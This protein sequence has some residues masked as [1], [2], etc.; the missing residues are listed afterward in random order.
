MFSSSQEELEPYWSLPELEPDTDHLLSR[1][2]LVVI[3]S[4]TQSALHV[5][6]RVYLIEN[7][8]LLVTVALV[9]VRQA[10]PDR[11]PSAVADALEGAAL[12]R[13]FHSFCAIVGHTAYV[14]A[15][16]RGR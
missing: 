12:S 13:V 15:A 3:W 9:L 14:T 7:N 16:R 2:L 10:S 8:T 5:F 4:T 6:V 1:R 11:T